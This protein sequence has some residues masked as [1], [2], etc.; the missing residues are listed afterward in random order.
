MSLNQQNTV[1]MTMIVLVGY[2]SVGPNLTDNKTPWDCPEVL[3]HSVMFQYIFCTRT[4]VL[5]I[6]Y[7]DLLN[8]VGHWKI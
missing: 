8:M 1:C 3:V 5:L 7:T 2:R 4:T 6:Q